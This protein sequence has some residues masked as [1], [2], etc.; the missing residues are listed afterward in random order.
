[1]SEAA[2]VRAIMQALNHLPGVR[3]WR[4]N[5]GAFQ[6]TYK[7]KT[8]YVRYGTPGAA[9]ITG[10]VGPS[11]RRLEI[12]V[13]ANEKLKPTAKQVAYGEMIKNAGGIWFWTWAI[14]DC[15]RKLQETRRPLPSL[16]Q[17]EIRAAKSKYVRRFYDFESVLLT[18]RAHR[19]LSENGIDSEKNLRL[20]NLSGIRKWKHCGRMTTAVI[21]NA[22]DQLKGGRE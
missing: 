22:Q 21:V 14:D 4:Q 11:G 9:D 3:V 1:M 10:L 6:K 8:H 16:K 19:V 13:K 17:A 5:T 12:E 7:G 15:L 20:A 2:L 18:W